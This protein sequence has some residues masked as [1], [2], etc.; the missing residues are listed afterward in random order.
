[1]TAETF[2][3]ETTDP[4]NAPAIV[5]GSECRAVALFHTDVHGDLVDITY[6]CLAD[7]ESDSRADGALPWPG[8]DWSPDYASYCET[9]GCAID[10]PYSPEI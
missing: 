7:A 3:A 4:R 8:F 10:V 5:Q 2:A 6:V 9:C 1:M